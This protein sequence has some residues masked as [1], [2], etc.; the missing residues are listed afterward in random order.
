[1][2]ATELQCFLFNNSGF[3]QCVSRKMTKVL[4]ITFPRAKAENRA[5][6]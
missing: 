1:M 3:S 2:S 6:H 4:F 5:M